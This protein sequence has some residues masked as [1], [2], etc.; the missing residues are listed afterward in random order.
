[1]QNNKKITDFI[2]KVIRIR[3][4]LINTGKSQINTDTAIKIIARISKYLE[5]YKY[6]SDY[7]AARFFNEHHVYIFEL[8]PGKYCTSHDKLVNDFNE[9]LDISLTI[10]NN[11]K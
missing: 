1:M 4:N 6:E 9:I 8:I 11:K 7:L 3:Q 2:K 5:V 10:L